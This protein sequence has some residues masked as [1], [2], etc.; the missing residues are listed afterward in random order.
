MKKWPVLLLIFSSTQTTQGQDYLWPT[1]ASKY[2]TSGFG[3]SRP[4]RL[5]AAI[6]VKTWN[7]TGYKIFA[8]RGGYLE[9]M[10]V[11]PFGYGRVLYLRL[12]TGEIAVYAHLERFNDRLQA[13]A[14]AEQERQGEYRIEK[15]FEAGA[16]PVQAGEMLGYTGQSGIGVPHLHFEMRDA[17]NRPINPLHKKFDLVDNLRPVVKEIVLSPLAVGAMVDGGFLAKAFKPVGTNGKLKI[18]EPIQVHGKIGFALAAHDQADGASNQFNVHRYRLY[19]DDRLQ[20]QSQFDRFSYSENKLIELMQDYFLQR[21]GWGRLHKLYRDT[22]NTMEI[23]TQLN[24]AAGA[25]V[26]A[27][28]DSDSSTAPDSTTTLD[29]GAGLPWGLHDFRLVAEDF[30][31]NAT[32]VEGKLLAGSP[33]H[34]K[35]QSFPSAPGKIAL[36]VE[37]ASSQH[38][39]TSVETH[40]VVE[41]ISQ[42]RAPVWRLLR[43]KPFA[44][45]LMP[46]TASDSENTTAASPD[47]FTVAE[48]AAQSLVLT[49]NSSKIIRVQARD[50][51]GIS[52]FPFYLAR[53]SSRASRPEALTV[54]KDFYPHFLQLEVTSNFPMATAPRLILA[55]GAKEIFA[56]LLPHEPNRYTGVVAL[57]DIAADSVWLEVAATV[58]DTNAVR[59]REAFG[60]VEILP[61]RGGSLRS[62]DDRMQVRF[63]AAGV[64]WPIYGRVHV[65]DERINDPRVAGPVYRAEPQDAPLRAAAIVEISYPDTVTNPQNWGL[66]YR[67]RPE[68]TRGERWVFMK[69]EVNLANKK[70]STEVFSLEDFALM[71]DEEP[72]ELWPQSPSPGETLTT[73]RPFIS[74][75]VDDSTSGFESE[76]A[77][78]LRLDGVKL[79]AEYDPEREIIFYRPKNDLKPGSHV[80]VAEA[81][82][83]CGNVAKREMKFIVR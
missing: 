74:F 40:G 32:V 37:S 5:H 65:R 27:A 21:R 6:D 49:P 4:R 30:F 76:R 47:D 42:P 71:H 46:F 78:K 45:P 29:A 54:V 14:E 50:R 22:G 72:P 70:L 58:N 55:A 23:Y 28:S 16:L 43:A 1:D 67:D 13:L 44:S 75:H 19:I 9:R 2:L 51:H 33:F 18:S 39:M 73:R 36:Q 3:E 10:G 80:L 17:R 56:G 15:Y 61:D 48:V 53:D 62:E 63:E 38:R 52:S 12:D 20:F 31:G 8:T 82:D 25:I 24:S 35:V 83:R 11:S 77:I 69:S 34:L 68:G 59:W 60:N 57:S 26:I 41:K 66:C 79:I 64:Y 81:Q 7:Q